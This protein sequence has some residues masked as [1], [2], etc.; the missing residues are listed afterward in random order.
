MNSN[1]DESSEPVITL[2]D[3]MTVVEGHY[4]GLLQAIKT[5]IGVIASLSLQRR[6]NC[7]A[8]IYEGCSGVGK[9]TV[10]SVLM[11]DRPTTNKFMYRLDDFTP[12]SFVSHAANRKRTDLVAVDLLPKIRNKTLLTKELAPLFRDNPKELLQNFARLTSVLD[13]NGYKTASG[14]HGT[15]GY[16]GRYVFNWIGATTQIPDHTYDVMAQ[17][18]NRLLFYEIAGHELTEQELIDFAKTYAAKNS[19]AECR[20]AVNNFLEAHFKKYPVESVDPDSIQIPDVSKIVRYAQLI[21]QGRVEVK[22]LGRGLYEA[23]EPE[24][25][26]RLILLLQTQV[27]GLALADDRFYVTDEDLSAIRHVALSSIPY[28]RRKLLLALIDNQGVLTSTEIAAI[29]DLTPPTVLD[30]M[31]ELAATGIVE[32][33]RGNPNRSTPAMI[34]LN[35]PWEWLKATP[36]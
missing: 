15:R 6:D 35:T 24:A 30:R 26:Q 1:T 29:L 3:V 27:R 19:V 36:P 21:A 7:L 4:S 8:L 16:E 22:S 5:G 25:P 12:A 31:K 20:Q 28:K 34:L 32:F 23:A 18:G 14:V 10:V 2:K 9:S 13:G 17:L 33:I 11:P